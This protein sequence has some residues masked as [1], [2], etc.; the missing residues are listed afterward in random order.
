[1]QRQV[2]LWSACCTEWSSGQQVCTEK[3]YLEKQTKQTNKKPKNTIEKYF[4]VAVPDSTVKKQSKSIIT[5]QG[6]SPRVYFS[7]AQ[8]RLHNVYTKERS[9]FYLDM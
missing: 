9:Y 6:I 1:M 7:W 8:S 3:F 2:R 5:Q 4:S